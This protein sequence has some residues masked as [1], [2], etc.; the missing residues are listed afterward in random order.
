[1]SLSNEERISWTD[2][3]SKN[4]ALVAAIISEALDM[5]PAEISDPSKVTIEHVALTAKSKEGYEKAIKN[6]FA[7]I[8]GDRTAPIA[9]SFMDM[10]N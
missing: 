1:M 8:P 2:L 10:R 5:A 4:K 7:T 3:L 6:I 9:S